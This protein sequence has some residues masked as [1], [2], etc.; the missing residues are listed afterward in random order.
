MLERSS[1]YVSQRD[2]SIII[3]IDSFPFLRYLII[4]QRFTIVSQNIFYIT[5]QS[6]VMLLNIYIYI[7]SSN[8][9]TPMCGIF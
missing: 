6:I 7:Y 9:R 2:V 4:H 3:C 5:M 8:C 1:L